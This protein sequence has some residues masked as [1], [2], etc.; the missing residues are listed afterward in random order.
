MWFILVLGMGF[1]P[2]HPKGIRVWDV[3][4]Y[5]STTRA[6][7]SESMSKVRVPLSSFRSRG[8]GFDIIAIAPCLRT[9]TIPPPEHIFLSFLR[10]QESS[11]YRFFRNLDSETSTTATGE[12]YPRWKKHKIKAKIHSLFGIIVKVWYRKWR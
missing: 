1:E 11:F 3:R 9:S 10:M 5:H 2:T 8:Y 7:K 4:V 6:S 12:V